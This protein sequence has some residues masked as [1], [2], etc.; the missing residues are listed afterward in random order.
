MGP[1]IRFIL[2]I[3]AVLAA[4]PA[5]ACAAEAPVTVFAAA[6]LTT[7]LNDIAA[8]AEAA[9]LPP[10][11]CVYAASSAL[12]R[13]IANGAPADIYI[14]ANPQWM[15]YL[16]GVGGVDP[17]SRRLVAGNRLTLIAPKARPFALTAWDWPS[18]GPHLGDGWLAL[19]DPDHVPAGQYAKAA[20]QT[21]NLWPRVS[22]RIAR[23]G[24]VR[25]ALALV[26]RG[27]AAAG[28]VYASDVAVS[29]EVVRVADLPDGSHPA[30]AYP[31]ALVAASPPP[32]VVRYF[33]YLFAPAAQA[34]FQAHGF[35]PVPGS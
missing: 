1:R 14:S 8:R 4:A 6:S 33:A 27:E 30:I 15:D 29:A 18:L 11:R 25:A 19:G 24:N 23:A 10:C 9:S 12:A 3:L 35:R 13:Q 31:A 17:A 7:V 22:T 32:T 2:L 20:L 5:G 16:A 34:R 28:I 26:A 21:L